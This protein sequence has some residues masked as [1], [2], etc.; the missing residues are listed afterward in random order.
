MP[1]FPEEV[2]QLDPAVRDLCKAL[3]DERLLD[4]VID[5]SDQ[6]R[7]RLYARS[8]ALYGQARYREA[9]KGFWTLL[10]C[11]FA[12]AKY[13]KASAACFQML[14]R[15]E[16]ASLSYGAAYLLNCDDLGLLFHLAQ[17]FI[18]QAMPEEARGVLQEL[19]DQTKDQ[20]NTKVLRQ[21]ALGLIETLSVELQA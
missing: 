11:N 13:H 4:A 8:Y 9:L 6:E 1:L 2:E 16:Q 18:A 10:R 12:E 5:L 17:C 14:G 20:P 7:D 15:Y 21:R 3:L 19:L